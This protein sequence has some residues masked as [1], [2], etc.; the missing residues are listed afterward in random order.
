MNLCFFI[1]LLISVSLAQD[2]CVE[3]Y[4]NTKECQKENSMLAINKMQFT[5]NRKCNM[6]ECNGLVAFTVSS[7]SIFYYTDSTCSMR[8]TE[9][10]PIGGN[11][12]DPYATRA[13]FG[14][15]SSGPLKENCLGNFSFFFL[16][17]TMPR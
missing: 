8:V 16:S 13:F 9:A 7:N 12:T 10:I 1:F 11:C 14:P 3:C 5:R 17:K 4:C 15:C 2:F 6:F